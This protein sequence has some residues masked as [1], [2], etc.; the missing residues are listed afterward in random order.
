[1]FG[2]SVESN[3]F[4]S[5]KL[6]SDVRLFYS[7]SLELCLSISNYIRESSNDIRLP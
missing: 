7:A 5:F 4:G 1:M 6:Y 2:T 3:L